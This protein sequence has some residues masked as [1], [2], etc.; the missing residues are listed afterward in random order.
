V[1]K[2]KVFILALITLNVFLLG[3]EATRPAA[4]VTRSEQ[5]G[6]SRYSDV[7]TIQLLT[8]LE[9]FSEETQ[10]RQ[11]FTV[12]PF[13]TEVTV[14]AIVEMLQE[15]TAQVRSRETKAFVD[16][17]Y[18]VYLPSY[19]E[20]QL[21]NEAVNTLYAA[22]LDDVAQIREGEFN[23]SV[24]L[25][26]FISQSNATTHRDKIREMGF[27]AEFRIQ[28]QDESRFW[29]DYEQQ[30]GVEYA[31]RVLAGFVPSELHM[32][33]S[34]AQPVDSLVQASTDL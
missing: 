4:Q 25:G 12:G 19:E 26:Y 5:T 13:E 16:R 18:W 23:N 20:E 15:Y 8:E 7:P 27:P 9:A 28:R 24:S 29:V 1:N 31:S 30:T 32:P 6:A 17:G 11:C 3:L 2:L 33:T 21:A 22:G 34:C 10:N 14:A